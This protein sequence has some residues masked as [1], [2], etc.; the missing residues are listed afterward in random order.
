[1]SPSS[2]L[3][4]PRQLLTSILSAISRIPDPEQQPQTQT[5]GQTT[6]S[7]ARVNPSQLQGGGDDGARSTATAIAGGNPLRLIG[8]AHRS[9]FTTLHVLFP[10]LLL[11]ALDLLDRGLVTCLVMEDHGTSA[12][13]GQDG[14]VDNNVDVDVEMRDGNGDRD[15]DRNGMEDMGQAPPAPIYLVRSAAQKPTRRPYGGGGG[16]GGGGKGGDATPTTGASY[17]VQ[18]TAWN[19]TC[20]AFAFSAFPPLA[21]SSSLLLSLGPEG[22]GG[23][24]ARGGREGKGEGRVVGDVDDVG[25][26]ARPGQR[27]ATTGDGQEE[28]EEEEEGE[29]NEDWGSGR[30]FGGLSFDGRDYGRLDGDGEGVPPC[31]K[32]LLACVLAEWWGATLGRYMVRRTVGREEMAGIFADI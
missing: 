4:T 11:P 18:T 1:M 23:A 16:G 26:D 9:L 17:V 2:S 5:Q 10:S 7:I 29:V 27:T 28:E 3:P 25:D 21:G 15:R 8:P 24:K 22:P 31:C 19:C 12:G 14:R 6:T 20:A 32:H 30:Q 13:A